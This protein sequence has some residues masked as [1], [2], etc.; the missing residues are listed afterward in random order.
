[1]KGATGIETSTADFSS[2]KTKVDDLNVDKHK[3]GPT[4]LSKLSNVVDSKVVKKT[5]YNQLV[6]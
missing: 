1:M 2:L 5:V 4:N 6:A 3:N